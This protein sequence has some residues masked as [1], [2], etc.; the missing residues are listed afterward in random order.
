MHKFNL[1]ISNLNSEDF[2][3]G[4]L[5]GTSVTFLNPASP[6]IYKRNICFPTEFHN[7]E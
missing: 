1:F 4:W 2:N 6:I 5:A 3:L 7:K